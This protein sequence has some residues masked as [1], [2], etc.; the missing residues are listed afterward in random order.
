[1]GSYESGS[2]ESIA[3]Q[4][5]AYDLAALV[6]VA[7]DLLPQFLPDGGTQRG[8]DPVNPRLVRHYT[9]QGLLDKPT[10]QGR[11]ARYGYRH[12]LQLLVVRRLLAE[13]YTISSMAALMGNR[14]TEELAHL[15][16]GGIKLTVEAA[17]PALAF[18]AQIRDREGDGP[19][20]N[21]QRQPAQRGKSAPA[22]ARRMAAPPPLAAAPAASIPPDPEPLP[23]WVRLELLDGLELHVRSDVAL[24][25]T[26]QERDR[27][28]QLIAHH[29]A[30]LT[31]PRRP[32]P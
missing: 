31:S 29:L 9:T 27:L 24:P 12:L 23:T 5:P 1:M 28:L 10:R 13:G 16:Q 7:N 4:Q 14:S 21:A 30:H 11:E 8:Q 18:L 20:Q 2:L 26:A 15:L 3:K 22:P 6:T 19:V 17:N 32:P 25:T